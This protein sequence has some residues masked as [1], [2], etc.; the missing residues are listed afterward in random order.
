MKI[1]WQSTQRTRRQP[2]G[3]RSDTTRPH[4][5]RAGA[6]AVAYPGGDAHAAHLLHVGGC[7][8][9]AAGRQQE[10]VLRQQLRGDDA[11]PVVRRLEVRVLQAPRLLFNLSCPQVSC[12]PVSCRPGRGRQQLRGDDA[13]PVVLRL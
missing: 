8:Q 13:P 7:V 9:A 11:P 1:L 3:A 6:S 12:P 4:A 2:L 10:R 5:A